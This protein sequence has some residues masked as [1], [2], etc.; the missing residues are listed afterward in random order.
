MEPQ[1]RWWH[2]NS[3]DFTDHDASEPT[4]LENAA[5]SYM[6]NP[7]VSR[8]SS[9]TGM[10]VCLSVSSYERWKVLVAPARALE[11]VCAKLARE[12]EG[13]AVEAD[14]GGGRYGGVISGWAERD[15]EKC[16]GEGGV[17]SLPEEE[18]D[19]GADLEET[20]EMI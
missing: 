15:S 4:S 8:A 12:A 10:Q 17:G 19:N 9:Y 20:E 3:R 13:V 14:R 6:G 2:Q 18:N 16:M 1:L 11:A 5:V 7:S